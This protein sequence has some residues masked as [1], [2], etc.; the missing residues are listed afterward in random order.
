MT[1][2][3]EMFMFE[4]GQEEVNVLWVLKWFSLL[5]I[6]SEKKRWNIVW[7]IILFTYL[8][9][10]ILVLFWNQ[11]EFSTALCT[12]IIQKGLHFNDLLTL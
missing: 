5:Q 12:Y 6:I 8:Q 11:S 3:D 1:E 7:S 9:I 2:S 10:Y 4:N